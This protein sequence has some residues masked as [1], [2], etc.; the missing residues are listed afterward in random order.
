MIT[1]IK[2]TIEFG[3][4]NIQLIKYKYTDYKLAERMFYRLLQ[5]SKDDKNRTSTDEFF[6]KE[7][8]A[9]RFKQSLQP[10]RIIETVKR[11]P[12]IKRKELYLKTP[13]IDK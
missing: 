13:G 4:K 7:G 6:L 5:A 8:I 1:V 11:L 10:N 12:P 3:T 9:V 2:K